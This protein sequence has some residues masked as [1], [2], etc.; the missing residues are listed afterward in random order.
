MIEWIW[1]PITV[2]AALFQCLRTALQKF[3][4]GRMSTTASTFTRF[5]FGM[6]VAIVYILVLLKIAGFA[7]PTPGPAFFTKATPSGRAPRSVLY[8][9]G[10]PISSTLL[11]GL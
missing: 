1:I 9:A 10:A 2:A 3:L 6:P 7:T 5:A 8:S 4:K 11:E